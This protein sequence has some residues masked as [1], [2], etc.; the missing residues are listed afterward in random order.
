MYTVPFGEKDILL[1]LLL[2][3]NISV[4]RLVP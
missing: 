2:Y 4:E 1:P 3:Y